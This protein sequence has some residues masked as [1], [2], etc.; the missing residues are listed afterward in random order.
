SCCSTMEQPKAEE[1]GLPSET[2]TND[3]PPNIV[4]PG[5]IDDPHFP[6]VKS[7]ILQRW[8]ASNQ[9]PKLEPSEDAN[10]SA[11][12][13]ESILSEPS[14]SDSKSPPFTQLSVDTTHVSPLKETTSY[15]Q[16]RACDPRHR[17]N[18][19]YPDKRPLV[20]E[21]DDPHWI[22]CD[23]CL[24]WYHCE[25]VDME[26]YESF[27]IDIFSCSACQ[28]EHGPSKE[29]VCV[30]P[31]RNKFD[32][33]EEVDKPMEVGTKP[34]VDEFIKDEATKYGPPPSDLVKVLEIGHDFEGEFDRNAEWKYVYLIKN[35]AGLGIQMP[36]PGEMYID[37]LVEILGAKRLVETIDV[38]RQASVLMSVGRYRE[39]LQKP[40]RSRLFNILSLEFTGTKLADLVRPPSIV[41]ELSWAERYWPDRKFGPPDT[42]PSGA[43]EACDAVHTE[44]RPDVE[45]FCLMGMGGSFTDYH[46]DFGG[47]SV[48]YHVYRGQKIFY[49]V[50]PTAENLDIY[51]KHQLRTDREVFLGDIYGDKCWRVVIEEGQTLMI[52]AGWIHAVYTPVDSL[53]FGGNFLTNLNVELQC[54]V[55]SHENRCLFESRY[56]YPN[57]EIINWYAARSF[58]EIIRDS[59][60]DMNL[61]PM[62][63]IRGARALVDSLNEWIERDKE[64]VDKTTQQGP[65][66]PFIHGETQL[67]IYNALAKEYKQMEKR[68]GSGASELRKNRMSKIIKIRT[69][70]VQESEEKADGPRFRVSIDVP[71]VDAKDS[72]GPL[73]LKIPRK[74][75]TVEKATEGLS[76][77]MTPK[78][79]I[80]FGDDTTS[81]PSVVTEEE[82][83]SI[84]DVD[85]VSM[86]SSR[87]K[88]G[89]QKKPAAWLKEQFGAEIDREMEEGE[90][91][92]EGREQRERRGDQGLSLS[93]D[94]DYDALER[95]ERGGVG[96]KAEKRKREKGSPGS[97]SAPSAKERKKTSALATS[98]QRLADKMK[99]LKRH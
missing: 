90:E 38:Y 24:N 80:R 70:S 46:I 66:R 33:K 47:S 48:W 98:K 57:F 31:H 19:S 84:G 12:T 27:L 8:I 88:S 3:S 82:K 94:V 25:C 58:T 56:L 6:K 54:E 17:M 91:G 15:Y 73:K 51:Q 93:D 78:L 39:L 67:A 86:F 44:L 11:M 20:D 64:S 22:C 71:E 61:P 29:K 10:S 34:W 26:P 85:V 14:Q 59:N 68:M 99:N 63:I 40:D 53:V 32:S 42:L 77:P 96:R 76:T 5:V 7:T 35:K 50:E 89:R 62:H 45:L 92:G 18:E 65:T 87:S 72:I 2:L 74:S 1:A 30:A 75:E 13:P 69:E 23:H 49:V 97:S 37:E 79:R 41:K 83:R 43:E 9:L 55:N 4:N 52:P 95:A 60:D 16:C 36:E 21:G 81:L 28:P